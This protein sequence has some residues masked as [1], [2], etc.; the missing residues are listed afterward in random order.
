V[1]LELRLEVGYDGEKVRECGYDGVKV[2]I[3]VVGP[4]F[5][6]ETLGSIS[7][8]F[9]GVLCA[10][11]AGVEDATGEISHVLKN[12]KRI[13]GE[14]LLADFLT[15]GG[16]PGRSFW[17][18][19]KSADIFDNLLVALRDSLDDFPA[20]R[21]NNDCSRAAVNTTTKGEEK[22]GGT[23]PSQIVPKPTGRAKSDFLLRGVVAG[24]ECVRRSKA[25]ISVL[26]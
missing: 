15:R 22:S 21:V 2:E 7:C 5:G 3:N 6:G 17:L 12:K 24:N 1:D 10:H 16:D 14:S 23:A 4:D 25:R 19:A 26:I 11:E 9:A 18:C 13:V 20:H 8:L